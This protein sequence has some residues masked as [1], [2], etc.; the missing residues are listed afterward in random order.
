MWG[1]SW[2]GSVTLGKGCCSAEKSQAFSWQL[3]LSTLP[4]DGDMSASVSEG[5]AEWHNMSSIIGGVD[6]CKTPRSPRNQVGVHTHVQRKHYISLYQDHLCNPIIS[7]LFHFLRKKW[8]ESRPLSVGY[9]LGLWV[10]QLGD[11][12][13]DWFWVGPQSANLRS[14][15]TTRMKLYRISLEQAGL[16]LSPG[17]CWT[18]Q[19]THIKLLSSTFPYCASCQAS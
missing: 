16:L 1:C 12:C 8:Q 7:L 3:L 13:V 5:G 19:I 4:V 6:G 10:G 17:I 18:S 9:H 14:M 2:K 11:S 15:I